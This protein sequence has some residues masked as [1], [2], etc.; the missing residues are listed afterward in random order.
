LASLRNYLLFGRP[1]LT[2]QTNLTLT[3]ST[4]HW[5]RFRDI[6]QAAVPYETDKAIMSFIVQHPT[7]YLGY[8][9]DR[10]KIF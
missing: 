5:E 7:R 10:F 9:L 1:I 8:L 6:G 2:T 4:I 3:S